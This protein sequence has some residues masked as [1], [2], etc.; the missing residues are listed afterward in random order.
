MTDLIRSA[1]LT[2]YPEIARSL[3]LDPMRLLDACGIDRRCL[4]DPDIKLPAG[5]LGRLIELSAKA[6][7]AEDF[8]LRLAETRTLSVLGPVGLLVREE[9]TVRDALTSLMRYIRL[10]NEALYLRLEEAD[11]EAI[12]SVELRVERPIP[13]RQGVELAIG[14][15]YRVLHSLLGARWRPLVCFAHGAPVRLETYRRVFAH[16]VAFSRDFNGIVC[17]PSDLD[18]PLPQSD[19]MLARYARRHLEQMLDRP[20]SGLGDKVRELVWLQLGSGHCTV[21]HVAEQLGLDRSQYR[22]FRRWAEAMLCLAQRPTMTMDEAMA[23]VEIELEAQHFLA[24][25]V[26]RRRA[27]PTDDVVSQLATA[28]IDGEVL[29]DP[30]NF[31]T[32]EESKLGVLEHILDPET[33][34]SLYGDV[35]HKVRINYYPPRGDNKEGWDNIDIFGWLGY[36]MQLKIDF[37]CRDSILAA[38]LALDLVLFSD[39]AQRAGLYGI[40]EWLSFYYKA[41]MVAPGLYAEHDLFI[42]QTKLKNTLRWMM[43]EDQIT[44][45]GREYYEN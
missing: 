37:L 30:D 38:P 36:P 25:E 6:A 35:Y 15:L 3:G 27:Q 40:Q 43:G 19:P 1:C 24:A 44:H 16:R 22:R 28:E 18:R 42:Q 9:A 14:V 2:S 45:L 32:K 13:V 7:G 26:D 12:I 20:N 21:E 31:K 41:P 29:D 11:D 23:E 10:H 4:D 34:P 5:A 33:F 17:R 39:L 8:G